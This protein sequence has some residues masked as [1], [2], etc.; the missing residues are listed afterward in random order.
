MLLKSDASL[1]INFICCK[2]PTHKLNYMANH[3]LYMAYTFPLFYPG[4][5]CSLCLEFSLWKSYPFKV[6]FICFFVHKAYP[7]FPQPKLIPLCPCLCLCPCLSHL[8][9]L[10]S[11]LCITLTAPVKYYLVLL[12]LFLSSLQAYKNPHIPLGICHIYWAVSKYLWG[13]EWLQ[14]EE[15]SS[16]ERRTNT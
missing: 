8:N 13:V 5:H 10:S 9:A 14:W 16:A 11:F 6:K 1:L 7:E 3:S 15:P 4:L 2:I 12:C